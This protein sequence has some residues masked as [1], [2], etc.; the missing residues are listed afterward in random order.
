MVVLFICYKFIYKKKIISNKSFADYLKMLTSYYIF[1]IR[2]KCGCY[3][4]SEELNDFLQQNYELRFI[5]FQNV[6]GNIVGLCVL[7]LVLIIFI[8]YSIRVEFIIILIFAGVVSLEIEIKR[9]MP[10]LLRLVNQSQIFLYKIGKWKRYAVQGR[11][12]L[13]NKKR[14]QANTLVKCFKKGF[15]SMDWLEAIIWLIMLLSSI[16]ISIM[17]IQEIYFKGMGNFLRN[18]LDVRNSSFLSSR[19]MVFNGIILV[20]ATFLYLLNHKTIKK[21]YGKVK[22]YIDSNTKAGSR[23]D[24]D[25]KIEVDEE[26]DEWRDEIIRMC[27][28]AGIS[29]IIFMTVYLGTK[30]VVSCSLKGE[31]PVVAVGKEL[32]CNVRQIGNREYFEIVKLMMAHEVVHICYRDSYPK[33]K[34]WI[35]L[36]IF[37]A[38]FTVSIGLALIATS[39]DNSI[40]TT[41]IGFIIIALAGENMILCDERYWL[42][43]ME[44]RADRIGMKYS[45]ASVETF[46]LALQLTVSDEEQ[47]KESSNILQREFDKYVAPHIHPRPESRLHEIMKGKEWNKAEYF[48]YFRRI[49]C[50]VIFGK[51]WII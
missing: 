19:M 36:K 32:L 7:P 16:V 30:K 9:K 47:N 8:D 43:V 45:K 42:Q 3:K 10:G 51:G 13:S 18:Q 40:V 49:V 22:K 6:F 29:K 26:L 46:G 21:T 25:R 5:L 41:I 37:I 35:A 44:F 14:G 27:D 11:R 17:V 39:I 12:L 28:E 15:K 20:A 50:N 34:E 38:N 1:I 2:Y 4:K 23:V 48:R 31:I 24:I 33:H